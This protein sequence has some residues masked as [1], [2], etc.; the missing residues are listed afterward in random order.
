LGEKKENKCC[1][2]PLLQQMGEYHRFYGHIDSAL[3][4]YG[5]AADAAASEGNLKQVIKTQR[6]IGNTHY[7]TGHLETAAKAYAKALE[8]AILDQDT[9]K[10]VFYSQEIASALYLSGK[11]DSAEAIM[12]KTRG[13]FKG[14]SASKAGAVYEYFGNYY[15]YINDYGAM[16]A[17]YLTALENYTLS[18]DSQGCT[19][20]LMSL[21]LFYSDMGNH[22]VS[23][24]YYRARKKFM[25]PHRTAETANLYNSIGW[26]FKSMG[27]N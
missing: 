22:T 11:K 12:R 27:E 2:W 14:V 19:D 10:Q 18:G 15:Y 3:A 8:A 6:A 4:Y 26:A 16:L 25:S 24:D 20:V 7:D 13:K 23:L 1:T 17:N 5:L 21:A 9:V